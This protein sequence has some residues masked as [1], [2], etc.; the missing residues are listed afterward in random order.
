M[1]T[2]SVLP[3]RPTAGAAHGDWGRTTVAIDGINLIGSTLVPSVAG[4]G[5]YCLSID[6]DGHV[7][8]DRA[9]EALIGGSSPSCFPAALFAS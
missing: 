2:A 7:N 6:C 9:V 4:L 8:D 1:V 3:P 5:D